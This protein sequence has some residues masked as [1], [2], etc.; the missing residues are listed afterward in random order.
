MLSNVKAWRQTDTQTYATERITPPV[1]IN[2]VRFGELWQ[3]ERH[4][5]IYYPSDA[6][7][8]D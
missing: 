1:I 2:N 3:S 5:N 4:R 7:R 6:G 8:Q